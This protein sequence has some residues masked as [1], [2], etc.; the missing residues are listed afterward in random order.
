MLY[1]ACQ[2]ATEMGSALMDLITETTPLLSP[3]K[4]HMLEGMCQ[5]PA[6][7]A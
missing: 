3:F 1:L 5:V 6:P 4:R 7:N 2:P